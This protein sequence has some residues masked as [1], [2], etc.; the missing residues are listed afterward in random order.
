MIFSE[1]TNTV[2]ATSVG[3]IIDTA[4]GE[5]TGNIMDILGP[6]LTIAVIIIAVV[7]SITTLR[8]YLGGEDRWF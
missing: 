3:D 1:I 6:I 7:W 2:Y 4:T 5:I 8:W